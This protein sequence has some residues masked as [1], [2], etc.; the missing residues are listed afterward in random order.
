MKKNGIKKLLAVLLAASLTLSNTI[1][2]AAVSG[3]DNAEENNP[4][5]DGI[6]IMLDGEKLSLDVKPQII[7]GRIMI[8]MRE[9]FEALK[10]DVE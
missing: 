4:A 3:S 2:L 6:S 7:N 8:P 9:I 5:S 1:A 10:A